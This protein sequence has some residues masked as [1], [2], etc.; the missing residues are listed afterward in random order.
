VDQT[1]PTHFCRFQILAYFAKP[2]GTGPSPAF[3]RGN[4]KRAP[5]CIA[6]MTVTGEAQVECECSQIGFLLDEP[7]Q[8]RAQTQ[9]I[10][11]LM[12]RN[13]YFLSENSREMKR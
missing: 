1:T 9:A 5:E 13:S 10:P 7:F 12:S 4:T 6:E 2:I 11:I 3:R 8:R